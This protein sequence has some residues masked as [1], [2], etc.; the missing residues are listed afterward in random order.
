MILGSELR[1][2]ER[3]MSKYSPLKEYLQGSKVGTVRLDFTEVERIL[4]FPLPRSAYRHAAWWS[5]NPEGHSHCSAWVAG[6]WRSE[7]VDVPGRRVT[8]RRDAA[9][10]TV[11]SGSSGAGSA[12]NLFGALKDTVR[13]APD[14]DPTEPT[15][16]IWA[17]EEGRF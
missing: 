11:P 13:F 17:A 10:E 2:K 7:Q 9:G 15:G 3:T 6:G 4:G 14:F 1:Q 12:P 16:E 8:F 5:N